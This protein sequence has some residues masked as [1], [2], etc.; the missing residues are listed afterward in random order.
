MPSIRSADR[1]PRWP[2]CRATSTALPS[3]IAGS[4][5][6]MTVAC[7][8]AGRIIASKVLEN[9]DAHAPRFHP[10]LPD[11]RAAQRLPSHPS[12]WPAEPR[13]TNIVRA[14][15]LLALSVSPEPPDTTETPAPDRARMLPRPCPCCGG[16]M[17][18]NET[19]ARGCQPSCKNTGRPN[20]IGASRSGGVSRTFLYAAND[21]RRYPNLKAVTSTGP[22]V[23]ASR[24]SLRERAR[25]DR[26]PMQ[27][28]AEFGGGDQRAHAV[29]I[30][31]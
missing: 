29:A 25:C 12:R 19:F 27:I 11:A 4:S 23:K 28:A 8:S 5:P 14:R 7:R 6:L 1:G 21:V 16:R 15:E 30:A 9:H 22:H 17:F 20:V 2:I 31:G 3:P 13:S 18:I 26:W 10:A 24:I